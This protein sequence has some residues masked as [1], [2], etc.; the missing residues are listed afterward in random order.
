MEKPFSKHKDTIGSR[1]ISDRKQSYRHHGLG[2]GE[3]RQSIRLKNPEEKKTKK[4]IQIK[5]SK[6]I[7]EL[8]KVAASRE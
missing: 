4:N 7:K 6:G 1:E 3:K 5:G 8:I 2:V